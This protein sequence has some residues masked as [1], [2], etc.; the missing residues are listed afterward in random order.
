MPA[1]LGKMT[2]LRCEAMAVPSA[3]FEWYRDERR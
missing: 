2:V 1:H 3:A